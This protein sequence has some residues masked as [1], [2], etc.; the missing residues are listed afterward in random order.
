M[1]HGTHSTNFL[2]I[3]YR[4]NS[5]SWGDVLTTKEKFFGKSYSYFEAAFEHINLELVK[6]NIKFKLRP[7]G[8]INVHYIRRSFIKRVSEST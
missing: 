6:K 2:I 7:C 8:E 4:L 3:L 1:K 5:N